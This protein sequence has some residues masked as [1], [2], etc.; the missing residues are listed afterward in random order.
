MREEYPELFDAELEARISEEIEAAIGYESG[1]TITTGSANLC[2]GR[3]ANPSSATASNE[4]SFGSAGYNAGA[5]T[6]EAV[7]SDTTWSVRIYGTAYKILLK[8]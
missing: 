4:V 2:L 5:V 3:G 1:N 6:T 7:V 8:A